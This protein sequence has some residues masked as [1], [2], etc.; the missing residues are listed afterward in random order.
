MTN[1]NIS[2]QIINYEPN[3]L[4]K[5][6]LTDLVCLFKLD[7]F[8]GEINLSEIS[9]QTINHIIKNIK[10]DLKYN[11]RLINSK[12]NSLIG[13]SDYIIPLSLIKKT[14]KNSSFEIKKKCSLIMIESTKRI[15]F[16]AFSKESNFI[17][18]IFA[19]V[20]I[21]NKNKTNSFIIKNNASFPTMPSSIQNNKSFFHNNISS[22]IALN[23]QGKKTIENE[24]KNENNLMSTPPNK[25]SKT[26]TIEEFENK[27]Y[28]LFNHSNRT[29]NKKKSPNSLRKEFFGL[30]IN[31]IKRIKSRQNEKVNNKHN[32][33]KSITYEP[34]KDDYYN[35]NFENNNSC[36]HLEKK[37]NLY[38][39]DK[40]FSEL[41]TIDQLL[42]NNIENEN[43]N[44]KIDNDIYS[45]FNTFKFNYSVFE[46][47][48]YEGNN[49]NEAYQNIKDNIETLIK[50]YSLIMEKFSFLKEK[51]NKLISIF[52]SNIE[53]VNYIKKQINKLNENQI[54]R[55]T[56]LIKI[57]LN[58]NINNKIL[59]QQTYNKKSE[60][61][62]YQNIFN[63]FYFDL[64]I[65]KYKESQITKEINKEEIK[66]LLLSLIKTLIKLYGN[67]SQIYDDDEDSKIRLKA[68]L[69]RYNIKETEENNYNG[70]Q[71]SQPII[72]MGNINM[73]KLNID[74]IKAIKEVD[75][76][77][78]EDSE[79]ENYNYSKEEKIDNFIKEFESR[80]NRKIKFKKIS[81]F[82][83][84]YGSQS[85]ILNIDN[86][87]NIFVQFGNQ[88]ITLEKYVEKNEK[89]EELKLK[90]INC[91][92]HKSF[93][94]SSHQRKII[95]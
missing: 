52:T 28:D 76:E 68:L 9:F 46:K 36:C 71:I 78:E 27:I 42:I 11:I 87:N 84:K 58:K 3:N 4:S 34:F 26:K 86:N 45:I 24:I 1:C 25:H 38:E 29:I 53:R 37:L 14:N 67:I 61:I 81:P 69:F 89:I 16:G 77:K 43:L 5:I 23:T 30:N 50:Y 73:G 57:N 82:E 90:N 56:K 22:K 62:I 17:I 94:K 32:K 10:K 79:S 18:E 12:S 93:N 13:I 41:S 59:K 15:L 91:C 8:E 21:L 95:K 65:Q 85:V 72:E 63:I 60:Y 35:M 6:D 75:E 64:D 66:R 83:Y 44:E 31:K 7:N 49:L 33:S 40:N 20:K 2:I 51:K 19:N 39:Q 92:F 74:K 47:N 54:N 80:K 88:F 55:E 48:N 70:F